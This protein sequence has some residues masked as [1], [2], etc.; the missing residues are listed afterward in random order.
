[1]AIA[2][3]VQR[4]PVVNVYNEK[5]SII[6][7]VPGKLHGFTD[8]S[9]SIKSPS[10]SILIYNEKGRLISTIPGSK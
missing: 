6:F 10:G 3:A 5:G 8:S 9:V 4:G 1:M 2:T 7:S